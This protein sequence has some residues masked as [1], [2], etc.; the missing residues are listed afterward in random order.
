MKF[1]IRKY[2]HL[3]SDQP[4][5]VSYPCWLVCTLQ[6]T[7][8]AVLQ[9]GAA[10]LSLKVFSSIS[11]I[12]LQFSRSWENINFQISFDFVGQKGW[13][14]QFFLILLGKQIFDIPSLFFS[15]Y[16]VS[17]WLKNSTFTLRARGVLTAGVCTAP[18]PTVCA[19]DPTI[20][21]PTD[22]VL[23]L[24]PV[25]TNWLKSRRSWG[26]TNEWEI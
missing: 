13:L 20:P 4:K 11:Q 17:F 1:S 25:M 5:Q 9:M 18:D 22:W 15:K 23:E 12:C 10:L 8:G 3:L 21:C 14:H 16:E 7:D 26:L 24:G 6:I 19:I 2:L